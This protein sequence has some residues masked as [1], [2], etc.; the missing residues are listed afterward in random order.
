[1]NP[2]EI[3]TKDFLAA[4]EAYSAARKR[5]DAAFHR[6]F[7]RLVRGDRTNGAAA[8]RLANESNYLSAAL[9]TAAGKLWK[10]DIDPT[11]IVPEYTEV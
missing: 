9:Y 3:A 7:N 1:M 10:L 4:H 11:T 5:E 8:S 6:Y 2:V